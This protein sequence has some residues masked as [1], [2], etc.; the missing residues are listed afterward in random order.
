MSNYI[1]VEEADTYISS[2][3]LRRSSWDAATD[4]DKEIAITMATRAIDKLAY[5]E[6]KYDSSQE[7]QFPRGTDTTV[8]QDI[9]DACAELAF[10]FIDGRDQE[11]EF[12]NIVVLSKN[13]GPVS[14]TSKENGLKSHI[15]AGIPSYAAWVL[16]LPYLR[17]IRYITI[18]R[19]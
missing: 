14:N 8:P 3:K 13:F 18:E 19:V 7:N 16:L 17:D 9:L 11:A 1:L 10:A 5:R 2:N 15:A 4:E 12:D 6:E